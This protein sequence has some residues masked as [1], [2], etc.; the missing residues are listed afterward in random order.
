MLN[1]PNHLHIRCL[2]TRG[3]TGNTES[4][5]VAEIYQD[6]PWLLAHP[7]VQMALLGSKG[8]AIKLDNDKKEQDQNPKEIEGVS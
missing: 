3:N 1:H 5:F 4:P 2:G 7:N 8:C 6:H